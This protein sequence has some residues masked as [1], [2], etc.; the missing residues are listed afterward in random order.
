MPLIDTEPTPATWLADRLPRRF[1]D[2]ASDPRIGPWYA[3]RDLLADDDALLRTWHA[4][5][6]ADDRTTTAAAATYLAGWLGGSLAGAVGHAL[7]TVEAGFVVDDTVRWHQHPDGWIDRVT[8]GQPGVI[9]SVDHPWRDQPGVT[10]IGGDAI[11]HIA[12]ERLVEVLTPVIDA[13]HDLGGTGRTGLWNEVADGLGLSV[14][15]H[16]DIPA[17]SDVVE[18]LLRAV[19]TP[20][21]PWR[22]TPS[23][24]VVDTTSGPVYIGQKGGCCLAYTCHDHDPDRTDDGLD[25]ELDGGLDGRLDDGHRAFL[26]RFPDQPGEPPYCTTCKFRDPADCEQRQRFWIERQTAS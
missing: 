6:V 21:V 11:S 19:R 20:G 25:D 5:L 8:L 2:Y 4:R 9:V 26:E 17:R 14:A 24:R 23:L 16:R 13:C 1:D 15:H 7:A 22:A 18:T 12:V 3:V 10:I